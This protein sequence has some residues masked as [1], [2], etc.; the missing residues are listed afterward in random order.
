ME[1]ASVACN[2]RCNDKKK[3]GEILSRE[4]DKDLSF[5]VLIAFTIPKAE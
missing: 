1:S 3:G 5:I 4:V 2:V